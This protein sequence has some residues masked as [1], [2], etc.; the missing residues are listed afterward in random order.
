MEIVF[1][2]SKHPIANRPSHKLQ[3]VLLLVA[4]AAFSGVDLV[5]ECY[6][7]KMEFFGVNAYNG[8]CNSRSQL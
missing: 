2:R 5:D 1:S 4:P 3:R 7:V 6:V 8:P